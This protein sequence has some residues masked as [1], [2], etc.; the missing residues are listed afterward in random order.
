MKCWVLLGCVPLYLF[1]L[2]L[3]S[4]WGFSCYRE[5]FF[6]L[7]K[8]KTS[9]VFLQLLEEHAG[10]ES[11]TM[12]IDHLLQNYNGYLIMWH[13]LIMKAAVGAVCCMM[14]PCLPVWVTFRR[15]L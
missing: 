14:Q 8:K 3:N 15:Y 2:R 4:V 5:I 1:G 12:V 13:S 6:F 9:F 10:I 7:K 11:I